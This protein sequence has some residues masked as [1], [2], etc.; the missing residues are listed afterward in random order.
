MNC[1]ISEDGSIYFKRREILNW[2][3]E[4]LSQ[5]SEGKKLPLN[6]Y[7]YSTTLPEN[8]PVPRE[9]AS[10]EGLAE[11]TNANFPPC[12]YFLV[13]EENIMYVGQSINLPAR[14]VQHQ[15]NKDYDRVFYLPVPQS[16][17]NRV[18]RDFIKT[19]DPPLN[20]QSH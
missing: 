15:N 3:K 18:E 12:I 20:R 9:L 7:V 8:T 6:I 11:F 4:N 19:L 17:L 2:I 5:H 13:K 10:V 14:L 16:D 1:R